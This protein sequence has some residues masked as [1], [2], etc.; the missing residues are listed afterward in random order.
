MIETVGDRDPYTARIA[1]KIAEHL[2]REGSYGE[3]HVSMFQSSLLNKPPTS[4]MI[5][6][7]FLVVD[8]PDLTALTAYFH[9]VRW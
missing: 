2:L 8:F 7:I 5:S 6:L 3:S 9:T 1:Y 4:N